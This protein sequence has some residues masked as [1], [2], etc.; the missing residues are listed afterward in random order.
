MTRLLAALALDAVRE[1]SPF[2]PVSMLAG[3]AGFHIVGWKGRL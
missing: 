2:F 3:I 1:A